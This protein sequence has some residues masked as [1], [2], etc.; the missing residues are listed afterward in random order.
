MEVQTGP[1]INFESLTYISIHLIF[2]NL[3]LKINVYE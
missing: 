2:F 1:V 3:N